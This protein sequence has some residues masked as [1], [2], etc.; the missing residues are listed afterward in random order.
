MNNIPVGKGISDVQ[1][2]IQTP[3]VMP[4]TDKAKKKN[5][6]PGKRDRERLKKEAQSL[7]NIVCASES[8]TKHTAKRPHIESIL[9]QPKT[10]A[11]VFPYTESALKWNFTVDYN[12]H[13]ETPLQAFSDLL[14]F[15]E[16]LG[17]NMMPPKKISELIVYDP[18]WCQ[19]RMR[20]F[21][22]NLGIRHV[23]ND[24]RDFY[25]DIEAAQ[26][27]SQ[28]SVFSEPRSTPGL[29]AF[30]VLV[31]NPPYSGDHKTKLLNFLISPLAS[32]KPFALLL[33]AYTATKSYWRT[34][35]SSNATQVNHV[36]VFGKNEAYLLP[37]TSY[38]YSH[39]EGTEHDVPP[40]YSA[41]FLGRFP[42][43]SALRS[44]RTKGTT[45]VGSVSDLIARGLATEKRLNPKQRRK[46]SLVK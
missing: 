7:S 44:L 20:S 31:T 18:Y 33:P 16:I 30:D 15:L 12:D 10:D 37:A 39:P 6:R 32:N 3:I 27:G 40:F 38:E 14:P 46:K 9:P 43:L 24:N 11:G 25:A 42:P 1:L 8:T 21:L 22:N 28:T 17:A 4:V 29:P 2:N 36:S 34:Y 41:W 5:H 26:K 19:G 23:I 13:F 35:L 45:V